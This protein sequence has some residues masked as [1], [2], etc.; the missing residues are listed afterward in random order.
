VIRL[1]PRRIRSLPGAIAAG[2]LVVAGAMP[3]VGQDL[4]DPL[5]K[6]D[7][8]SRFAVEAIIDSAFAAGLPGGALHSKA[9]EGISK[10]ADTKQIVAAVRNAFVNLKTAR[11][12]LG[13]VPDEELTAAAAVLQAGAK[14]TQLGVFRERKKG[15]S[16]LEAFTVWA[17]LMSRGVPLDDASSAISKLW[18][19]GA[20]DMTFHRLWNDVQSDISSGLNPGAALSNRIRE[21]PTRPP[22][23]STPEE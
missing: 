21:S 11:A 8:T 4:S 16:D 17:D 12:T 5:A 18:Q 22:P 10:K 6:L 14:A 9:L 19:D 1:V 3:A 13:A 20:D 7:A 23:K 15:R 2:V